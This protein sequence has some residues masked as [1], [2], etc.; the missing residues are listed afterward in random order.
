MN[1]QNGAGCGGRGT[2]STQAGQRMSL[3][4]VITCS[5][6]SLAFLSPLPYCMSNLT[7]LGGEGRGWVTGGAV[8]LLEMEKNRERK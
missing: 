2:V 1:P 4:S 5:G 8:R 7:G 3:N 6:F